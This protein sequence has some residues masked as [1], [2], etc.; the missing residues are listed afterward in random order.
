MQETAEQII[1]ILLLS[2]AMINCAFTVFQM[3]LIFQTTLPFIDLLWQAE[4][5]PAPPPL[6]DI[7]IL[8]L[9]MYEYVILHGKRDFNGMLK[10]WDFKIDYHELAR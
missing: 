8:I 10:V 1:T 6:P 9:G 4:W 5:F 2:M 3:L 7:Q